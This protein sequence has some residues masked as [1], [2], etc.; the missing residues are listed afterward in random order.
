[1]NN[2]LTG[3]A[4]GYGTMIV[5]GI[6]TGYMSLLLAVS[7]IAGLVVGLGAIYLLT[8]FRR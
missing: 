7:M 2:N 4:V 5:I 8:W 3:V 1:M 6:V